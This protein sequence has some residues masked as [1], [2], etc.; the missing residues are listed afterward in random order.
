[1][2]DGIDAIEGRSENLSTEGMCVGYASAVRTAV[3]S[4]LDMFQEVS[5]LQLVLN[6]LEETNSDTASSVA[7]QSRLKIKKIQN[8]PTWTPTS[9]CLHEN[10]Q[11]PAFPERTVG[12]PIARQNRS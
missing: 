9:Q 10:G 11:S 7:Q 1:M 8:E 5:S 6:E 2:D 12:Y 4:T 3:P